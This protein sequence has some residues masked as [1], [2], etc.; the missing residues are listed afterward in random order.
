MTMR[1]DNGFVFRSDIWCESCATKWMAEE[2]ANATAPFTAAPKCPACSTPLRRAGDITETEMRSA[3][4]DWRLRREITCLDPDEWVCFDCRACSTNLADIETDSDTW[5]QAISEYAE[6]PD[7]GEY[8]GACSSCIAEPSD[9]YKGKQA[10]EELPALLDTIRTGERYDD[11][12][13]NPLPDIMAA[14]AVEWDE[15][16]VA[17]AAATL[18]GIKSDLTEPAEDAIIRLIKSEATSKGYPSTATYLASRDW[19]H[20][21]RS[22]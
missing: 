1:H 19:S 14:L 3:G 11:R 8:C 16:D 6:M 4:W 2:W 21:I 18:P 10:M 5:P 20:I 7:E 15:Q 12:D 13:F 17:E 22:L 9:G